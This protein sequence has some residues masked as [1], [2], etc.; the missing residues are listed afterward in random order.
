MTKKLL[1][2]LA[3]LFVAA[4]LAMASAPAHLIKTGKGNSRQATKTS[5][6]SDDTQLL[7]EDFEN[8]NTTTMMPEGW[9]TFDPITYIK[10]G[11]ILQESEGLYQAFEGS[12]ALYSWYDEE[13]SRDAWAISPGMTLEAGT[14]YYM[15]VYALCMGYYSPDE[16]TMTIGTAQTPEAQTNIIIDCSGIN[17]KHDTEWTFYQGTFTPETSG[18]YYIGIHHC[19][20][21][22]EGFICL[23]DDLQVDSDHLRFRPEG[24]FTSKGG[25]WS[26]DQF[27][28][29]QAGYRLV[30]HVYTYEGEE[31]EYSYKAN[32]CESVEWDF[33]FYG[34]TDDINASNP[35][36]TFDLAEDDIKIFNEDL[37][38]LMNQDNETAILREY[39]M[40][41]IH[42]EEGVAD[43]VGNFKPEDNT[44]TFST[45]S[46]TPNEALIGLNESYKRIAERFD[47][48]ADAKTLIAGSYV[49]FGNYRI[50]PV[51]ASKNLK[52][53]ILNADANGM[54]GEAVFS[55]EFKIKDVLGT[56]QISEG[57]L[58]L[59]AIVL[60]EEVEVTGTFFF[61]IEFPEITPNA[62]N[63]IFLAHSNNRDNGDCTTYIYNNI[64]LASKPKGWY[65]ATDYC[66]MNICCGIY[67]NVYFNDNTAVK[68]PSAASWTVFVNGS[69]LNIV[70]A[71]ENADI[72][73]TDI[74]GRIVFTAQAQ[75]IKT[76]IETNLN[77][78]VYIVTI[79]GVSTK[80]VI[81]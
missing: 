24:S 33:G 56:N 60:E 6:A 9:V 74:A 58:S 55:K 40:T 59:G 42:G 41:R 5:V 79:D 78:G 8:I 25:L 68:T 16:W 1:F 77:N 35:I 11:N 65:T 21:S 10:C 57:Y 49:M 43:C 80:V 29:D 52:V 81:R 61:E 67:P 22:T 46:S 51:N 20:T 7:F 54:P 18:T 47:R 44:Y 39:Y 26:I 4:N 32:H 28:A 71:R 2:G 72:V 31:F 3:T 63:H 30:P 13:N 69:E 48:P 53:R 66:D 14:T 64:D 50:S 76:S 73:I 45:S 19:T 12:N 27:L 17:S 37:L 38:I 34:V 75:A 62:N 70:N 15:G 36:V 23:W